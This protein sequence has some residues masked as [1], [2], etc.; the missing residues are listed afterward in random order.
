MHS[1]STQSCSPRSTSF[2]NKR[3]GLRA[4]YHSSSLSCRRYPPRRSKLFHFNICR[5][6]RLLFWGR[7][8]FGFLAVSDVPNEASISSCPARCCSLNINSIWTYRIL[9]QTSLRASWDLSCQPESWRTL[10]RLRRANTLREVLSQ[11]AETRNGYS[12]I[13]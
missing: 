7:L 9:T 1:E 12:D 13:H 4:I 2:A 6:S 11:L 8:I 10:S 5:L 3:D